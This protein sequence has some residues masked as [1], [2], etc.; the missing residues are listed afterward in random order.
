MYLG[1]SEKLEWPCILWS[2]G[3]ALDSGHPRDY[4]SCTVKH[5][6]LIL[7]FDAVQIE[8]LTYEWMMNR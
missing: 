7:R 4:K 6:L 5:P 8:L 3:S 1:I 2:E